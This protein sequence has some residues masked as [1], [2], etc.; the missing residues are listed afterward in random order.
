MYEYLCHV[1]ELSPAFNSNTIR[2][3]AELLNLHKQDHSILF[4]LI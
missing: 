2:E 3:E 4:F 1:S